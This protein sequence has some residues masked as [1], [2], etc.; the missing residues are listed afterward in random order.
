MHFCVWSIIIRK[1][2][3]AHSDKMGRTVIMTSP[4]PPKKWPLEKQWMTLY[5]IGGDFIIYYDNI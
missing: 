2:R 1:D 3:I 5:H 4:P